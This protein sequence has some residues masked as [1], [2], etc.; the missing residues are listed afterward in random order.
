MTN[1]ADRSLFITM[2]LVFLS[3]DQTYVFLLIFNFN[4]DSLAPRD[5]MHGN[6]NTIN[7]RYLEKLKT[8]EDSKYCG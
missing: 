5:Q 2:L 6:K 3:N 8:S 7:P 1:L 4:F